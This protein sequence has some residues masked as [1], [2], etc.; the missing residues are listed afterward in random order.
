MR[1]KTLSEYKKD[2]FRDKAGAMT[3]Y[4]EQAWD[5]AIKSHSKIVSIL[6]DTLELYEA[7]LNNRD[8]ATEALKKYREGMRP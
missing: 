2:F 3:F 4:Q 1:P 8:W 6:I 7:S 5:E